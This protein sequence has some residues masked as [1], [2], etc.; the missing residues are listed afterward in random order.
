M[1][2]R[3][4][5]AGVVMPGA[6][7]AEQKR[8]GGCGGGGEAGRFRAGAALREGGGRG[9]G[10]RRETEVRPKRQAG[11]KGPVTCQVEGARSDP[12]DAGVT[13]AGA[14]GFHL[15]VLQR[16][17]RRGAQL[18]GRRSPGTRI[19]RGSTQPLQG[20]LRW[21]VSGVTLPVIPARGPG[22]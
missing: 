5:R 19:W 1:D 2:F 20:G 8:C 9:R 10:A 17:G 22:I 18:P 12:G 4:D 13:L 11:A 21:M 7:W 14:E 3:F 6:C 15:Q 16:F